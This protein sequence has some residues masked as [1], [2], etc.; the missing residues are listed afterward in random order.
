MVGAYKVNLDDLHGNIYFQPLS[1]RVQV[2]VISIAQYVCGA[3]L[4]TTPSMVLPRSQPPDCII[5]R[6]ASTH[7]QRERRALASLDVAIYR[8][9]Q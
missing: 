3:S 1:Y 5:D 7:A 2:L 6:T 9:P 4:V 8:D